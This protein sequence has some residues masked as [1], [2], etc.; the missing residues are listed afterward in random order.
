MDGKILRLAAVGAVLVL[1]LS[2]FGLSGCSGERYRVEYDSKGAYRNAK[3]SYRAGSRVTLY[4]DLIASDTDY[5]FYLDGEPIQ[6][7]YDP[8]KGFVLEFTM[9][10]HDVSLEYETRNSM[11]PVLTD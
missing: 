2:L 3:D 4:F 1:F 8:E 9:P 6:F 7:N 11:L 10:D 5:T